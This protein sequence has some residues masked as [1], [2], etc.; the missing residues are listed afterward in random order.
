VALIAAAGWVAVRP[1]GS[2]PGPTAG[3]YRFFPSLPG[4]RAVVWAVG[5][6]DASPQGR[7]VVRRILRGPV[8]AL[9]YLGDVYEDGTTEE[10]AR[11]YAPTYGRLARVTAPTSGNHDARNEATGYD[12]YW[13]RM[14]GV[15]PPD[16]Y[17]F[18]A[19]GWTILSLDS[20][21]DNDRGSAQHR[22]LRSQVRSP[23][24]CRLA[25]WHRARFSA[26]T[27][28][29]DEED[30]ADLWNALRRRAAIVVAGHEHDMQ[31]FRPIDGITQFVSGAGGRSL[32]SL[33]LDD[34]LAFGNDDTYGALR[35]ELRRGIARHAFVA[36]DGR[37]L[38][39]GTVRC[40][41]PA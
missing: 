7:A 27:H 37:V 31:R 5:D 40:R 30:V 41:A 29:G 1:A 15:R 17:A 26:G 13:R 28:H 23:G 21:A 32:Y 12:R 33:R 8:D 18:R 20:E 24:T 14:H 4:D 11:N 2:G 22:W 25:F 6:G 10:Y 34:R 38:D 3:G 35:L 19:G 9:L 36:A 39:S 16:W